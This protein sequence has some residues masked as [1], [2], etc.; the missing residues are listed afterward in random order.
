MGYMYIK[1]L[2]A[3][4]SSHANASGWIKIHNILRSGQLNTDRCFDL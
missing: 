1:E 2:A 3:Q 4:F